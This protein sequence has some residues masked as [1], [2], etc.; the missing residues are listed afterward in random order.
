MRR[1]I[2][3]VAISTLLLAALLFGVPL[4]LATVHDEAS[5]QRSALER[6]A[7]RAATAVGPTLG[8][9]DAAELPEASPG[10]SVAVFS[11]TGDLVQGHAQAH[12]DLAARAALAH[13][14][15][16]AQGHGSM[17]VAVPVSSNERVYA[18]VV[19]TS[20]TATMRASIA[21]RLLVLAGLGGVAL[22]MAGGFAFWQA[23]R[24]ARPMDQLAAT[25]ASLGQGDFAARMPPSGV[26][27]IDRTAATLAT[28]AEQLAAHLERERR[29]AVHASHQLRTPLTRLLLELETGLDGPPGDL[30]PA[31]RRAL[32]MAEHLSET[33][34]DVLSIARSPGG[35][36]AV[37]V[38]PT[39]DSLADHWRGPLAA[40]D[41]PLRVGAEPGL[42]VAASPAALR[43]ILQVLLDNAYRHGSGVV[44]VAARSS[45]RAVAIDVTD[46]GSATITWP[47]PE[48]H[49]LGLPM[50][51]SVAADLGGRL[52][53]AAGPTTR[54]T[55]LLP[56]PGDDERLAEG[57]TEGS[58]ARAAD[59][60][61]PH[62]P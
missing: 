21:R 29:F 43:Q 55:L 54:F 28:T 26:P 32:S 40:Q 19:A 30:A 42:R 52:V 39:L 34:D 15:T 57:L 36:A 12:S 49:H 48:D 27:E 9:G 2:L 7:L 1:R 60:A 46:E 16:D 51:R 4:T 10:I 37:A 18:V 23:R 5:T 50:A 53:F 24:L 44:S 20:S 14:A 22:V 6:A 8:R 25:A 11:P 61:E 59:A 45:G 31:A 13:A 33:V 35:P 38:E 41:R 56:R 3:L 62:A 17:A 47:P 58:R